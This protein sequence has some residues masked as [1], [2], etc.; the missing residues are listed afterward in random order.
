MAATAPTKSLPALPNAKGAQGAS[1]S[2]APDLAHFR[3]LY[4]ETVAS[5]GALPRREEWLRR[6]WSLEAEWRAGWETRGG[7][8]AERES[9]VRGAPP[10]EPEGEFDVVYAGGAAALLHAAALACVH[11]RR[12]LVVGGAR[13]EGEAGGVWNL[14]Q[15]E[16]KELEA[17][18]VFTPEEVG[19]AVL[20]RY[21]GGFVKFHDAASRVKAG[22]LWVSGAFDVA[23]DGGR[24]T[25]LAAARLA[26][27]GAKG[28]AV[29]RELR[30]VR[31]YVEPRRVTVEAEGPGGARR[32][33]AAQL[34]A[35]ASGADSP[36]ARQLNGGGSSASRVRP[37]V[38][39]VARGFARGVGRDEAD[40]QAAEILVTTEDASAHRQL[41]WEGFS[42]DA[43]RGEYTTRLFFHDAA[44]SPADK[45]L[46]A[47]FERYF[48]SLPA[49]KRRGAGWRVERPVFDYAHA[50]REGW[51]GRRRVA[52]ER[53]MLLGEAACGA[54]AGALAASRG[55]GAAARELRRVARLTERA[56]ATGAADA[57]ALA[58]VCEGP[59]GARVA[60]A[61]GLAEFMRPA[62]GGA[63]HAV[64]ETL[65]ALA[66]AMG[67][68]DESERSEVF[69]GQVSAGAL[70]RLLARTARLYPR[71]FARVR[72]RFGA[73]GA[74]C[75]V[76]GLAE[77]AWKDGG[78]AKDEREK[79]ER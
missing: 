31:A 58:E 22:P 40:F 2:R 42:G 15:D 36:V 77:A 7:A 66:A 21:Y 43:A 3:R 37:S 16:V 20:N 4:P 62:A 52:S 54:E 24:L 18:G 56:L 35:D 53:V 29:M 19:A 60:R 75:W 68:M 5:F 10:R 57:S 78:R 46:L 71:I 9:V 79:D 41:L 28:C 55:A 32:F 30:F 26:G 64:N 61:L 49:Y 59:G 23:L 1:G 76:A 51:R 11:G 38:G 17:A 34:F 70:R 73:R 63:P 12:A 47:L 27:P 14:S 48:E 6:I 33:F 8:R 72:E 65:N 39:T 25:A 74:L 45:S 44:D 50:P 67:G 69:R 13:A